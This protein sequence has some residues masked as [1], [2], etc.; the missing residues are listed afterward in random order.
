[1]KLTAIY[2]QNGYPQWIISVRVIFNSKEKWLF[3]LYGSNFQNDCHFHL[4]IMGVYN[5]RHAY[6]AHYTRSRFLFISDSS[7]FGTIQLLLKSEAKK[8]C[9]EKRE[10]FPSAAAAQCNMIHLKPLKTPCKFALIKWLFA[11]AA[12]SLLLWQTT[13]HTTKHLYY[14]LDCVSRFV[15]VAHTVY[16]RPNPLCTTVE[17]HWLFEKFEIAAHLI[18]R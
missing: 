4:G 14:T 15:S 1:M 11:W 3:R 13:Y 17:F 18:Y 10:E 8:T 2:P 6:D 16:L 9:F 5:E 12:I 7:I